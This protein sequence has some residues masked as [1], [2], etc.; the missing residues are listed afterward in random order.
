MHAFEP[1]DRPH[2]QHVVVADDEV[3]ALY[4]LD[5]ELLGEKGVLEVSRIVDPRRQDRHHRVVLVG[6]DTRQ[7]SAEL[8]DVVVDGL[9][10]VRPEQLREGPLGDDPILEQV[11]NPG[12][13][14]EVVLEDVDGAV[15][16]AHEIASADVCPHTAGGIEAHALGPEARRSREELGRHDTRADTALVVVDVVNE[17][18]Q[19]PQTLNEPA[20]DPIPFRSRQDA[21]DD[22]ERPGPVDR[23]ILARLKS[24]AEVADLA[25]GGPLAFRQGVDAEQGE[26]VPQAFGG[27]PRASVGLHQ[28]VVARSRFIGDH[29]SARSLA[30][31]R[32]LHRMSPLQVRTVRARRERPGSGL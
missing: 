20:P 27:G 32:L 31:G 21:G 10:A 15:L 29:R 23:R 26:V 14:A 30:L 7:Q 4:E 3:V 13:D 16:T 12:R 5:A 25:L 6:G 8:G 19:G 24:Y 11:R 17:E 9:D 28:L 2:I 18:V 1:G 22:V